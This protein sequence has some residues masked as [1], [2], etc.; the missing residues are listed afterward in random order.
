MSTALIMTSRNDGFPT[1]NIGLPHYININ[2]SPSSDQT[3]RN[4]SQDDPRTSPDPTEATQ[5]SPAP[6]AQKIHHQE[7]RQRSIDQ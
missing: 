1:A 7:L 3:H 2:S 5:R 6:V 4:G